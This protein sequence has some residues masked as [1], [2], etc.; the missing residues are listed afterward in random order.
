MI[1][2]MEI[3]SMNFDHH[4]QSSL[5]RQVLTTTRYGSALR[6]VCPT[7]LFGLVR[8]TLLTAF[9]P[10]EPSMKRYILLAALALSLGAVNSPS[11]QAQTDTNASVI[12]GCYQKIEG[13]LR[14][15]GAP[16][17]CKPSEIELRW[18]VAGIPGPQGATGQQGAAGQS[19]TGI[20]IP[21]GA[22]CPNGGV[23]YTSDSGNHFVCNGA[24]GDKGDQGEAPDLSALLSRLEALEVSAARLPG[25]EAQVILLE[26][27]VNGRA[28]VVN[29]NGNSLGSVSVI[30]T[31]TGAVIA[32]VP[33]GLGP[34]DIALNP[35][36]TR[37]YVVNNSSFNVSV[38][39]TAT[40]TVIASVA[41]GLGSKKVAINPSG[42]RAYI[43]TNSGIKVIDT[44]ANT[45]VASVPI[46]GGATDVT[47]NPTGTRAYA[48]GG[49]FGTHSVIDT[50]TNSIV[51]TVPIVGGGVAI[52]P[53]GTYAYVIGPNAIEVIDLATNGVI[54]A[55]PLAGVP[56]DVAFNPSG[57]R[58][59]VAASPGGNVSVIDT[60]THTIIATVAVGDPKAVAV[61]PAGTLL[62]VTDSSGDKLVVISTALNTVINT[63]AVGNEPTALAIK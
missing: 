22:E 26:S 15:V 18:N 38:I 12:Y 44:A 40:N 30:H 9:Q 47:V 31:E 21:P 11:A 29:N 36:G 7:L 2:N 1:W 19:V 62:Y 34:R 8:Q 60:A 27:K 23:M 48:T 3:T 54:T 10:K 13:Q 39:D 35:T 41:T 33:V 20:L 17:Q 52:N 43:T 5:E 24:K 49:L 57:T 14:R 16:G 4:L 53:A 55:V 25:L 6:A 61:N 42:T 28:Y 37:A 59:Y 46:V 58:A 51:G 56:Q 50:T 45:V 63:V 32:T